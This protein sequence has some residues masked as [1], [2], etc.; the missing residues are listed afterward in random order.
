[1]SVTYSRYLQD[2][3]LDAHVAKTPLKHVD[4]DYSAP[5]CQT[6]LY[7]HFTDVTVYLL[8]LTRPFQLVDK[9]KIHNDEG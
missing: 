1:M 8:Q 7:L 2:V 3:R 6:T 4:A 5:C 9:I